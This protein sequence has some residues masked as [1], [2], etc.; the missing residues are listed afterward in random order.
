[1]TENSID[2][3]LLILQELK[4]KK[5]AEAEEKNDNGDAPAN[6]TVSVR[7]KPRGLLF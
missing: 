1:M 5:E 2:Q 4:E 3:I 7:R 6:G